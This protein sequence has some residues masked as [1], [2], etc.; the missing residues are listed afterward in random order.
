MLLLDQP[1]LP[2]ELALRKLQLLLLYATPREVCKGRIGDLQLFLVQN[3]LLLGRPDHP[4]K[5]FLESSLGLRL[6]L[7][8]MMVVVLIAGPWRY[9]GGHHGFSERLDRLDGNILYLLLVA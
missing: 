6:L 4:S 2:F 8:K 1:Y 7:L 9:F 3:A 5:F